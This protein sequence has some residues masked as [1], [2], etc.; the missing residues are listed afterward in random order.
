MAKLKAFKAIRPARDKAHLVA[1]RPVA[2]YKKSV[3]SVEYDQPFTEEELSEIFTGDVHIHAKDSA[4]NH[5][6]SVQEAIDALTIKASA[7]LGITDR[8]GSLENGKWADFAIYS[9]DP[10]KAISLEDFKNRQADMTVLGGTIVYD[11]EGDTAE[12]WIEKMTEHFRAMN[13][14]FSID[15]NL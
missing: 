13:E 1:T 4:E 11:K 7:Y 3:F 12:R 5:P 9:D 2:S 15:E 14:D 6:Q 8:C 10:T